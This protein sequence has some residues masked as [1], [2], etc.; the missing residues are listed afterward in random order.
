[1]ITCKLIVMPTDFSENSL[2][3]IPYAVSL[4]QV[5]SAQLHVVTVHQPLV[6]LG[7]IGGGLPVMPPNEDETGLKAELNKL[8]RENLPQDL[9]VKTAVLM[10]RPVDEIINYVRQNNADLLVMA[11]HGHGGLTRA[12]MGSTAE[13]VVRKCSCPVLTLKQPRPAAVSQTSRARGH[14]MLIV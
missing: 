9:E 4:A 11:S 1:M 3:A 14:D 12:F 8:V 7:D 5:F 6:P 10:G 2:H 13:L